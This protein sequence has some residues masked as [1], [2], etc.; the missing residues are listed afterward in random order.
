MWLFSGH[1]ALKGWINRNDDGDDNDDDNDCELFCVMVDL[2]KS[3]GL[4]S[5][6]YGRPWLE[7]KLRS[8]E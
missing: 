7:I 8:P 5:S 1:Q 6:S 4:A 3:G 2:R